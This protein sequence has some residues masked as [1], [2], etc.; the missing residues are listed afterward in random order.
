[1]IQSMNSRDAMP[2][3]VPG[4][5]GVVCHE[6]HI[7]VGWVGHEIHIMVGGVRWGGAGS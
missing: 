3:N 6:I 5:D 2:K 4:W 1:M 7:M